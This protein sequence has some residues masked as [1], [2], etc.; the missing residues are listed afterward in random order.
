MRLNE[1]IRRN[2]AFVQQ[3][4]PQKAIDGQGR[5]LVVA[6]SCPEMAGLLDRAL[7]L[8]PMGA[9]VVQLSGAWG[10]KNGEELMRS[11][12]LGL[13]VHGCDEILVVGADQAADCP[14]KRQVINNA[15]Q[16]AGLEKGGRDSEK[17]LKLAQGPN[18]V[19]SGVA[20]TVRL[21]K[22][23]P[24]VPVSTPV[25]GAI[26]ELDTGL[27]RLTDK[28]E[29]RLQAGVQARERKTKKATSKAVDDFPLPE[30]P[31]IPL[32]ELPELD[33]DALMT[34]ATAS[35]DEAKPKP[36]KKAQEYGQAQSG[37]FKAGPLNAEAL[38][39][40]PTSLPQA[41]TH[42]LVPMAPPQAT[43]LGA[44]F[45]LPKGADI[46]DT[47]LGSYDHLMPGQP[48]ELEAKSSRPA[49]PDVKARASSIRKPKQKPKPSARARPKIRAERPEVTPIAQKPS[50]APAAQPLGERVLDF[51]DDTP[52]DDGPTMVDIRGGY[53]SQEG[54]ESPLDADLQ[55]ALIKLTRFL[56]D[57][58]TQ[59]ERD[60]IRSKVRRA[61]QQG[62]DLG[63]LIK[64]MISPVLKLGKKRYAVINE[65][66]KIKEDLP[67]QTRQVA[68]ALLDET[69][70]GV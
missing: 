47:G 36:S 10:G 15:L 24:Y 18:S 63:E 21:L 6:A 53:V 49:R 48:E 44:A 16:A 12:A 43:S 40:A 55:R 27:L 32:P 54:M 51:A 59:V 58:F 70:K 17:I 67:S 69:I 61:N 66:L 68:V 65:L 26:L 62:Q 20:E 14:P 1:V 22:H 9:V 2:A 56:A 64:L 34:A 37:D 8:E 13:Y 5:L 4:L 38:K 46:Q 60:D 19:G 50:H 57:E 45:D 41:Q 31:E 25:H 28:D 11:V 29:S 52:S 23:S 3:G 39:I 33:L 35:A 42:G 30:L 7:G